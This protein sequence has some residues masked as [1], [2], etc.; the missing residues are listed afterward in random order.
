M[1]K[2]LIFFCLLFAPIMILAQNKINVGEEFYLISGKSQSIA[3]QIGN[4]EYV[5][6]TY[7]AVKDSCGT[8]LV[9]GNKFCCFQQLDQ[10]K[11]LIIEI[12]KPKKFFYI[13]LEKEKSRYK[14]QYSK[15]TDIS[16][17]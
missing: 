5:S 17:E 4:G 3:T 16:Q 15:L 11:G 10:Q 1:E 12:D 14:F 7:L 2:S 13:Y 9:V 6:L 8:K